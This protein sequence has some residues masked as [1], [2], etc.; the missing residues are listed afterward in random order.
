MIRSP[1]YE[2]RV[3]TS[4]RTAYKENSDL[5]W[6]PDALKA[7]RYGYA[8][9]AIAWLRM[10][11]QLPATS[12]Q[13]QRVTPIFGASSHPSTM[14]MINDSF[15]TSPLARLLASSTSSRA[16]VVSRRAVAACDRSRHPT[17]GA[18]PARGRFAR[19][20]CVGALASWFV[21]NE[22]NEPT[23]GVELLVSL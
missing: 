20:F 17:S 13:Q 11:A 21:L 3:R 6:Q 1:T 7:G 16:S 9:F 12:Q 10:R 22:S 5:R 14:E 18:G 4:N 15:R 23:D 8:F 2:L 19:A